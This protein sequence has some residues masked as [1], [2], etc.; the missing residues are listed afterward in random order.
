MAEVDKEVS[1]VEQKSEDTSQKAEPSA[2]EQKAMDAGW[3][4]QDEWEGDPD[5]W[6]PA[7]E[8][9][10]RG[11][12]F[13]KIEDQ[14][15]TIKEFKKSLQDLQSHHA[16]VRETE[17]R[18][19]LESLKAQ[20]LT[21]LEE[22]DAAAVVAL[23]DRID[24]VREEQTR[25]RETPQPQVDTSPNPEFTSWMGRNKWYET[26]AAMK[27]YAD[28]VGRELYLRGTE[29]AEALKEVERKVKTE[30]PHKFRNP[31]RDKQAAVESSSGKGS[32]KGSDSYQ[33][34]DEERRVMQR[35]VRTIPGFSEK[36]YVAEL[37]RVKNG[38]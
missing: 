7:R 13:K 30:F 20:K 18:R 1:Q 26:E 31:N 36:D 23:D 11:E 14:N 3:V 33:L 35:F 27:A 6:R 24:L 37:K 17:Y 28:T 16:K 12:L 9:L 29:P 22:G 8:F 2:V 15:R 21:A 19:A 4:P 34:S 5:Q 32:G 10:D 25:L 38:A